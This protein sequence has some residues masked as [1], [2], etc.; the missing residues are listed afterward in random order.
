[1]IQGKFLLKTNKNIFH[2]TKAPGFLTA[3][4]HNIQ[5]FSPGFSRKD[6]PYPGNVTRLGCHWKGCY[7]NRSR[8]VFHRLSSRG[9]TI[10]Y[11]LK[12]Q[13]F[14]HSPQTFPQGFSTASRRMV[15]G[16]EIDIKRIDRNRPIPHFFAGRGFHHIR[17]FVQ[18]IGLD[19]ST[20]AGPATDPRQGRERRQPSLPDV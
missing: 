17:S 6:L 9:T 13:S 16:R 1:M 19:T 2:K 20:A 8:L 5:T 3:F 15:K 7:A 14:P 4:F 10:E 12:T 18:K 11:L